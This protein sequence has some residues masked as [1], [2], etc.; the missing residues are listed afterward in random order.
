MKVLT[1]LALAGLIATQASYADDLTQN[2]PTA[3]HTATATYISGGIGQA[4]SHAM[5]HAAKQYPLEIE[6][7]A[8]AK[9]HDEYTADVQLKITNSENIN[10]IS[11]T[12]QGPFVLA[13]IPDGKYRVE[14]TENGIT[15]VR[16]V[17]INASRPQSI[18]FEWNA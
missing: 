9:A 16:H 8:K 14:A 13:K 5:K 1:V 7:L 18:V 2:L 6:F 4:E 11:A 17:Q 3:I 10:I 15:K 12:N